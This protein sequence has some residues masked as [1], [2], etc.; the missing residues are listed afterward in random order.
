MPKA[1]FEIGAVEKQ[2]PLSR[3]ASEI[4]RTTNEKGERRCL[5]HLPCES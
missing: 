3:I 2:V 5:S 4:L 1:A